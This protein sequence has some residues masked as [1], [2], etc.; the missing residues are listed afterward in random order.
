MR[1]ESPGCVICLQGVTKT[2]LLQLPGRRPTA[3][4][5]SATATLLSL[6]RTHRASRHPQDL[7]ADALA[8]LPCLTFDGAANPPLTPAVLRT[9]APLLPML[10]SV[11]SLDISD[12]AVDT[13]GAQ[14][15]SRCLPNMQSLREV[16]IYPS[17]CW[18]DFLGVR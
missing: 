12:T 17:A 18:G 1:G 14:L 4:D 5:P 7:T 16:C 2:H 9:L 8:H 6:L 15:L 10:S 13:S 3:T 11:R